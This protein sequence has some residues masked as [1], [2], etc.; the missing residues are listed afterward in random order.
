MADARLRGRTDWCTVHGSCQA[1][2]RFLLGNHQINSELDA[3]KKGSVG[4]P[5]SHN[6]TVVKGFSPLKKIKHL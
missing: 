3:E 2:G 6:K 4:K 5:K 1:Q